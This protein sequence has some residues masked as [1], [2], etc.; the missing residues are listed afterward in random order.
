MSAAELHR[1]RV[2]L[3]YQLAGLVARMYAARLA[4]WQVRR[5]LAGAMAVYPPE[6]AP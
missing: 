6:A 4:S 1:A 5:A 2:A 3:H